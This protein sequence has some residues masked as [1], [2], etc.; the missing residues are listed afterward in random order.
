M[1]C[2]GGGTYILLYTVHVQ[3]GCTTFV[4]A[5][6]ETIFSCVPHIFF[7]G[8]IIAVRKILIS[9][10]IVLVGFLT[11]FGTHGE[12]TYGQQSA[13]CCCRTFALQEISSTNMKHGARRII[14]LIIVY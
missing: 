2:D 9:S 7:D 14:K 8:T 11:F 10:A 3:I 1:F 5:L 4:A 12:N 13:P 6:L